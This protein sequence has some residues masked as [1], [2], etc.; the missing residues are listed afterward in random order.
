VSGKAVIDSYLIWQVKKNIVRRPRWMLKQ[1]AVCLVLSVSAFGCSY[2]PPE[3]KVSHSFSVH[4]MNE[5]GPVAGLKLRVASFKQKEFEKLDN[6][7]QR[8]ADL[9]QFV[10]VIAESVTDHTGNAKFTVSK[11]GHFTLEPEHEAA[12]LDWVE[13]DIGADAG[14]TVVELKWPSSSVLRTKS[15][16]GRLS[17]GLMSSQS[18]PLRQAAL[19][20]RTL[21]DYK[22]VASGTTK[23][24]GSFGVEHIPDG[25]YFL[26]ITLEAPTRQSPEGKKG[27]IVIDLGESNTNRALS[28][29]TDFSSCGLSYDLEENKRRYA[30]VQCFKGDQVVPCKY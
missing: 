25:L 17:G 14:S 5:L 27:N 18:V 7:Q 12:H 3:Y 13:L 9:Q 28:I 20:V 4:V 29:S 21:V 8:T 6:E 22:E 2:F 1:F 24:D 16:Q 11:T 26:Q 30:P 19:R 23:D 10:E 15:L